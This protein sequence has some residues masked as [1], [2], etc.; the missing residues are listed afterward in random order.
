M[1][2]NCNATTVEVL[3]DILDAMLDPI[4]QLF[5]HSHMLRA[6]GHSKAAAR[7][8]EWIEKM[9]RAHQLVTMLSDCEAQPRSRAARD[10]SIG[11]DVRAVLRSDAVQT[12]WFVDQIN[13]GLK[14]LESGRATRMLEKVLNAEHQDL[15]KIET[16]IEGPEALETSRNSKH[17][18]PKPGGAAVSI[19]ALDS[20]LPWMTSAVSQFFYYSLIFSGEKSAELARR[21]LDA[22]V[23]MM[24]RTQALLERL[25][26]LGGC[27][28]GEGH[29]CI[30][31][32]PGEKGSDETALATHESIIVVLE[33]SLRGSDGLVDPMTHTLIDG[34]VRAERDDAIIIEKRLGAVREVAGG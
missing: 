26:D 4:N 2:S 6:W 25:L 23:R 27:P 18:L 9:R 20:P 3:Q 31:I 21:E 28:G 33:E 24:F 1:M 34:V 13:T 30:H 5:F 14:K 15:A 29:G 12:R 8:S 7:N 17:L 19:A 10:L 32:A 16:W 22:A 11:A